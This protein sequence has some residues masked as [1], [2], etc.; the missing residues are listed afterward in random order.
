MSQDNILKSKKDTFSKTESNPKVLEIG[1]LEDIFPCSRSKILDFLCV[2]DEYDYS[3]SD[4]SRHSGI[5]FK[6]ALNEVRVLDSEG[7]I[8]QT[9]IS[10]KSI[11]YKLN[12]ESKQVQL[13][14]KLAIERAV[15][16][17]KESKKRQYQ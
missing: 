15:R 3:I 14:N 10:G 2:F 12:L 5:S 4:I 7:I 6:T 8:K 17:V 11:M 16:R 1:P 9:R 13:I